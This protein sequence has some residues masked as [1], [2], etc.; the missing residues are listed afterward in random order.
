MTKLAA[1]EVNAL[2]SD[3]WSEFDDRDFPFQNRRQQK[4]ETREERESK[5]KLRR[6]WLD[7]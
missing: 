1:R 4:R 7:E 2:M 3:D 5:G 6:Q